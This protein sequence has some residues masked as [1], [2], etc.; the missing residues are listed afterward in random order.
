M[1]LYYSDDTVAFDLFQ[2]REMNVI[3]RKFDSG[4]TDPL[5]TQNPN[6]PN[7]ALNEEIDLQVNTDLLKYFYW[8]NT[9]HSMTD[10]TL[11]GG[12]GQF[13]MIGL[14]WGL[15]VDLSRV[16]KALPVSIG[17]YHYSQHILD[18]TWGYGHFPVVDAL[19]IKLQLYKR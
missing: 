4:G 12:Q 9:I 2:V 13:R 7:R 15:G 3:Y 5:I 11:Q 14:E 8:D 19:E 1:L 6:V 16:W 17:H 18:G 10:Q